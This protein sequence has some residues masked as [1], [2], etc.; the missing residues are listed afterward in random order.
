MS[1]FKRLNKES[2]KAIISRCNELYV[3]YRKKYLVMDEQGYKTYTYSDGGQVKKLNDNFLTAHFKGSSTYGVFSG[4][5][6]T[7]FICFDVDRVSKGRDSK[8]VETAKIRYLT[9]R[10][11]QVLMEDFLIRKDYIV[12][13]YSGG[14]GY[15]V[16]IFFD[17]VVSIRTAKDFFSMVIKKVGITSDEGNIEFRPT[18]T[19]GVKI[20][21]GKHKKTNKTCWYCDTITLDPIR[22]H[23]HI[24][25]IVPMPKQEFLDLLGEQK[26]EILRL[27][28]PQVRFQTSFLRF[29]N[30]M[31]MYEIERECREL[32]ELNRLKA[33][34]TRNNA[35]FLLSKYLHYLG[36]NAESTISCIMNLLY[37]TPTNFFS[38][39]S[40]IEKET[41]RI[42]KN[43]YYKSYKL[44][45]DRKQVCISRSEIIHLL[46]IKDIHHEKTFLSMLVHSKRYSKID[47]T[48]YMTYDTLKRMTGFCQTATLINHIEV[49]EE[50]GLVKVISRNEIDQ[51][52][53]EQNRRVIK[54][55]N[56]YR[57]NIPET[58]LDDPVI[59][60][61][62]DT[63]YLDFYNIVTNLLDELDLRKLVS[64]SQWYKFFRS[65]YRSKVG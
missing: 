5:Q 4:E 57:L 43:T 64:N 23:K 22:T 41:E 30:E 48:F 13:S 51:L 19:L 17:D 9:Y 31:P 24:L 38:D 63:L 29:E 8:K 2:Q 61:P 3:L 44:F 47:K 46:S 42:V 16:E 33:S 37:N 27:E 1:S 18:Q 39:P 20:P 54:K 12:V 65:C 49:L 56:V 45:P 25:N 10:L 36:W 35:T 26:E 14:K 53:L 28:L 58:P 6:N 50:L 7:K 52:E 32:L 15:H 55:P 40:I 62:D 60:I 59:V 34:G 21:L 11:I